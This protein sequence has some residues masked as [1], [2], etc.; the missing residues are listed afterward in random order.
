MTYRFLQSINNGKAFTSYHEED[1]EVVEAFKA[2]NW[3]ESL[4][5]EYKGFD[6]S[7]YKVYYEFIPEKKIKTLQLKIDVDEERE[8][9][10]RDA[11]NRLLTS[12]S[13][14]YWGYVSVE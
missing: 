7:P 1:S 9:E 6:K 11:L 5:I 13:V 14:G 12:L 4:T 2:L 10:V 8:S 3:P